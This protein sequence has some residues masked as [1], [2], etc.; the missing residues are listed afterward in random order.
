MTAPHAFYYRWYATTQS[1][2][3]WVVEATGNGG[4]DWVEL[5]RTRDNENFWKAVDVDLTGLLPSYSAVQFRFIAEDLPAGEII[6]AAL[7]DFTLYDG[8]AG[9]VDAVVLPTRSVRLDLAQSRPNPFID[10][11][12]IRFSLPADGHAVLSVFDVRG[13]RVATLVDAALEAG[14]H[15][16]SWNGRNSAGGEAASGVYFY[17]LQTKHEIRTKRLVKL[18]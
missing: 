17:K 12:S 2:D 15:D 4:A 11:T 7:D 1:G 3:D 5:E 14:T 9:S 13:A 10:E 18:H 16:A 6:E 8:G